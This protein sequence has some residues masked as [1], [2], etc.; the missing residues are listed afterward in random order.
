[1]NTFATPAPKRLLNR[2]FETPKGKSLPRLL[3]LPLYAFVAS[4]PFETIGSNNGEGVSTTISWGLGILWAGVSMVDPRVKLRRCPPVLISL[5]VLTLIYYA[6]S[7]MGDP[8]YRQLSNHFTILLLEMTLMTWL[9]IG[10]VSERPYL[11]GNIAWVFATSCALVSLLQLIG[12]EFATHVIDNVRTAAIG[13]DPNTWCGKLAVGFVLAVG[14]ASARKRLT[15]RL[16]TMLAF[17]C[18]TII[19]AVARSGSRTGSAALLAG[20]AVL[21]ITSVRSQRGSLF[22]RILLGSLIVGVLVYSVQMSDLTVGRWQKTL[23]AGEMANREY[24]YPTVIGMIAAKPFFGW[25]P[26]ASNAELCRETGACVGIRSTENTFGWALTSLGLVGAAPFLYVI[27]LALRSA[28]RLRV[29]PLG[30]TPLG[31]LTVVLVVSCGIEWY[32]VKVYWLIIALTV[33]AGEKVNS[34]RRVQA[35]RFEYREMRHRTT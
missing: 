34:R 22:S 30:W 8:T 31:A 20:F 18:F 19:L 21:V 27:G 13:E 28:W 5:V 4:I 16:A 11:Y 10:N 14:S 9:I 2:T 1:M 6:L 3:D 24:L 29:T 17:I 32:H 25:G 23:N 12:L 7:L 26:V 15:I 33:A 35:Q